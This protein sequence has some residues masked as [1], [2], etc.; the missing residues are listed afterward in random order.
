MSLGPQVKAEI[1]RMIAEEI[2]KAV[3]AMIEKAT[4]KV[5]DDIKLE[6]ILEEN[7]KNINNKLSED[8]AGN[9]TND[10]SGRN[11]NSPSGGSGQLIN[12]V[13]DKQVS[14][15][16]DR[17][18]SHEVM[19]VIK[20]LAN[21]IKVSL[22]DGDDIVTEYRRE[23]F[24]NVKGKADEMNPYGDQYKKMVSQLGRD[25][26]LP[27]GSSIPKTQLDNILMLN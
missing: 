3:P 16:I 24:A 7:K 20:T 4:K 19:P 26:K 21:Y 14:L 25:G 5:I 15:A 6:K 17:K 23:Q 12:Y 10:Y 11:N 9:I 22:V 2:Q 27:A 1:R 13:T 8:S 18:I